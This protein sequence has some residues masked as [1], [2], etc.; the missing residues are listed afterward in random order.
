MCVA[1]GS[2]GGRQRGNGQ[3]ATDKGNGRCGHGPALVLL[4]T[5]QLPTPSRPALS[6]GGSAFV[7]A[8]RT[9]GRCVHH[10]VSGRAAAD[11]V[12][13]G[14]M[15]A[16]AGPRSRPLLRAPCVTR[17]CGGGGRAV[18]VMG[19]RGNVGSVCAAPRAHERPIEN[20]AARGAVVHLRSFCDG[21]AA[22]DAGDLSR[23]RTRDRAGSNATGTRRR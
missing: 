3:A 4:P 19:G 17:R 9:S 20:S 10:R 15:S 14:V 6:G 7:A 12:R 22:R 18:G 5:R 1:V 2:P 16:G 11:R 13:L 21:C 23:V 8:G